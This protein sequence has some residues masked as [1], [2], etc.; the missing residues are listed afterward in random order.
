M[1]LLDD[2]TPD[3]AVRSIAE[4]SL[5]ALVEGGIRGLL[6]DVD[7]TLVPYGSTQIDAERLAW[8]WQ[9]IKRFPV[10]LLSNSVRGKR[11]QALTERLGVPG[12]CVWLWDRKPLGGGFRRALARLGTAPQHTAMIGDQLLTDIVGGNRAGLYT[13]W[14]QPITAREFVFTRQVSRRI[15]RMIAR[16]LARRGIVVPWHTAEEER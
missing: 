16:R 13:I 5:D 10:C 2:L 8:M 9:A 7:N 4:I 3:E 11:V 6:L 14:V 1:G 12:V 15:E